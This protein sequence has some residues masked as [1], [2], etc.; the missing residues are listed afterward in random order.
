MMDDADEI[1]ARLEDQLERLLSQYYPAHLVVG[2]KAYLSY[3]GP[4]KLGSFS[5]NLHGAKRGAWY[6]FSASIGGGVIELLSY[7]LTGRVNA[8][9]EAFK[10]ARAFLG[11][12]SDD[13]RDDVAKER[14]ENERAIA[15]RKREKAEREDDARRAERADTASD[16]WERCVPIAGTLAE[17]YLRGRGIPVP[18]AG[19]PQCLAFHAGLRYDLEPGDAK[20]PCLVARVDDVG[21]KLT[22]IWR[23]YLS[24]DGKKAF[25]DKISKLGFG[26]SAGGAVRIGGV[27]AKIGVAEG[28]ETSL[29]CWSLTGARFPVWSALSTSGMTGIELPLAVERVEIYADADAC[30]LDDD[31]D[32]QDDPLAPGL[33]AAKT[34]QKRLSDCGISCTKIHKPKVGFDF[35][36][37]L[38]DLQRLGVL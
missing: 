1:R 24:R 29:A 33:R 21:G 9:S 10:E 31:G 35:L 22:A 15:A 16:I 20:Y 5:I 27:G 6:R 2:G 34:L 26:P 3:K 18:L 32:P 28:I 13:I 4:K 37:T 36:D 7:A 30:R 23:I 8:Y 11:I 14:R 25:G 12:S 19:W 17:T 38:N